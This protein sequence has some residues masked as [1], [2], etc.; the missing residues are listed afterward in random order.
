[1][2]DAADAWVRHLYRPKRVLFSGNQPPFTAFWTPHF[3]TQQCFDVPK[4]VL[5]AS[6]AHRD[7]ETP[8]GKD[9]L[10]LVTP[11][12]DGNVIREESFGGD[13]ATLGTNG[14]PC[15]I[16]PTH[17]TGSYWLDHTFT[18]ATNH[19]TRTSQYKDTA[20]NA[21]G[22]LNFYS[23]DNDFDET[24]G[25]LL[26]S[27]DTAGIETS[28]E[29]DTSGRITWI[30]PGAGH[31]AW[32]QY[33]YEL[34]STSPSGRAQV[35][36]TQRENG[37][38]TG[39]LTQAIIEYDALGRVFRE[40]RLLKDGT[41]STTDTRYDFAGRKNKVSVTAAWSGHGVAPSKWTTTTYDAFGRPL[42]VTTPDDKTTTSPTPAPA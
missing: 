40:R 15:S 27:R 42:T 16:S 38:T 7:R 30:T 2:L 22:S 3:V 29:Y 17:T 31:G 36:I 5:L 26:R 20:G 9:L 18:D 34:A 21:T 24:S 1:M 14:S 39:V 19:Y 12:N 6:R 11:D 4:N 13:G 10:T 41:W 33:E 35:T 37:S 32:I 28:Y 25:R 8:D 23:S